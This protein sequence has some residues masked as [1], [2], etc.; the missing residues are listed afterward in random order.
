[1]LHYFHQTNR[2]LDRYKVDTER[3]ELFSTPLNNVYKCAI[4]ETF[5]AKNAKITITNVTLIAFNT[6]VNITSKSGKTIVNF[7]VWNIG[8]IID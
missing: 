1:M 6:D 7:I 4:N 2:N 3:L 8:T 5:T